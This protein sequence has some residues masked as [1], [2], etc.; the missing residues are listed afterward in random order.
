MKA[1][2]ELEGATYVTV[3]LV[4]GII[5]GLRRGLETAIDNLQSPPPAYDI[6]QDNLV[7][8]RRRVLPCAQKF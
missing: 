5:Y 2:K 4:F 3:I 6:D 1:Q 7:E 8:A